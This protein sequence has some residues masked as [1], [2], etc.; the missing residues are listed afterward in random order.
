MGRRHPFAILKVCQRA[1]ELRG[2]SGS[3]PA[4]HSE[5]RS[6]TAKRARRHPRR[7]SSFTPPGTFDHQESGSAGHT[8]SR[9]GC[10]LEILA[11]RNS[12]CL[13]VVTG[14][15]MP[16]ILKDGHNNSIVHSI[17]YGLAKPYAGFALRNI[18][19]KKISLVRKR[20]HGYRLVCGCV[21]EFRYSLY[22]ASFGCL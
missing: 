13:N 1:S 21:G 3:P 8:D 2:F 22:M 12:I 5:D 19:V 9:G 15:E 18:A 6:N 17:Y 14:W 11:L 7:L 20:C 4:P 10:F 16:R